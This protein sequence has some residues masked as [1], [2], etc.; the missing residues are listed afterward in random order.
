VQQLGFDGTRPTIDFDIL[1]LPQRQLLYR[2]RFETTTLAGNIWDQEGFINGIRGCL[3]QF[4]GDPQ[5]LAVLE[6]KAQPSAGGAAAANPKDAAPWW[7]Q[8]D[9]AAEPPAASF[10]PAESAVIEQLPPV[11]NAAGGGGPEPGGGK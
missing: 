8:G 2:R 1:S 11:R 10:V 4:V 3:Q 5:A 6:E 9:K 7:S